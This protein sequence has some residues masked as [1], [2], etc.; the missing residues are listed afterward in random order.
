MYSE[1]ITVE[2]AQQQPTIVDTTPIQPDVTS[3]ALAPTISNTINLGIQSGNNPYVF[4]RAGDQYLRSSNILYPFAPG[5]TNT[6]PDAAYQ[7]TV[8]SFNA[9]DLGGFTSFNYASGATFDQGTAA[10]LL[11]PANANPNC[12]PGENPVQCEINTLHPSV[13]FIDVG[14][15]DAANGTDANTFRTQLQQIVDTAKAA[16]VVPVLITVPPRADVSADRILAINEQII[17]VANNNNV[18]VLNLWL[19]LTQ[20]PNN[21]LSDGVNLS[22]S[23]NGAG[24]LNAAETSQYGANAINEALIAL[25]TDIRLNYLP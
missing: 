6:V 2:E 9:D 14:S 15:V 22:V 18:P 21:G 8:A 23:P 11:D 17:D 20:L 12:N 16:S 10:I 4:A 13:I 24:D 1:T 19:L 25:L 3:Q 7:Q 5:G